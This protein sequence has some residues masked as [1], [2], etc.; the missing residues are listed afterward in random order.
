VIQYPL[1]DDRHITTQQ[2]LPMRMVQVVLGAGGVEVS[3][4]RVSQGFGELGVVN[5]AGQH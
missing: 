1:Y 3:H 4:G 2:K 5:R